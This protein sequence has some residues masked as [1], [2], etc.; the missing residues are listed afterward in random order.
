MSLARYLKPARILFTSKPIQTSLLVRSIHTT[1]K[2]SAAVED[3]HP[4]KSRSAARIPGPVEQSMQTKVCTSLSL[5]LTLSIGFS[6]HTG[7]CFP[8]WNAIWIGFEDT[9]RARLTISSSKHSH[10]LWSVYQT[11]VPNTLIIPQWEQLGVV[12]V[13]LVSPKTIRPSSLSSLQCH[14]CF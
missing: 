3:G 4:P 6:L 13:R 5:V 11:T 8:C 9:T 14:P 12:V 10:R 7:Y 2:M 1:S